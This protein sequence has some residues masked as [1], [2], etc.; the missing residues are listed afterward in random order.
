[1]GEGLV[2]GERGGGVITHVNL[3]NSHGVCLCHHELCYKR[4]HCL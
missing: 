4:N 1:M 3:I 2:P